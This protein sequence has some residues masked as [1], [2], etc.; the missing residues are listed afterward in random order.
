M[1][2]TPRSCRWWASLGFSRTL[3]CSRALPNAVFF[4]NVTPT[5][6]S[7]WAKN[8]IPFPTSKAELCFSDLY[9]FFNYKYLNGI[10][11][12]TM[13]TG[14]GKISN[15]SLIGIVVVTMICID[16]SRSKSEEIHPTHERRGKSRVC[17][18]VNCSI[19][20][21]LLLLIDLMLF[22]VKFSWFSTSSTIISLNI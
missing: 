18:V 16:F 19:S 1:I 2:N 6:S 21:D 12:T 11:Q 9:I 13:R 5:S 4:C 20:A 14:C 22:V 17:E 7:K 10:Q 3:K 8:A 15:S